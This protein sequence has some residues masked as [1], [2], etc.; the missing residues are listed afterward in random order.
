MK[1]ACYICMVNERDELVVWT[2][3]VVAV[4]FAEVNVDFDGMLDGCHG[5]VLQS[6]P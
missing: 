3:R 5:L 1:P 2:A 6:I 4:G